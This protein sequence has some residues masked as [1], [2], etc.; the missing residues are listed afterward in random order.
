MK[1]GK[2]KKIIDIRQVD[3]DDQGEIDYYYPGFRVPLRE[4]SSGEEDSE[5][6]DE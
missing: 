2:I 4:A 1:G 5:E 6:D 3:E